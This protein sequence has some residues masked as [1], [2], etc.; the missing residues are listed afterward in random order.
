MKPDGNT[1]FFTSCGFEPCRPLIREDGEISSFVRRQVPYTVNYGTNSNAFYNPNPMPGQLV[2]WVSG[3]QGRKT[4]WG[5]DRVKE[6]FSSNRQLASP[7]NLLSM[8]FFLRGDVWRLPGMN[9]PFKF[10]V[11]TPAH[12]LPDPATPQVAQTQMPPQIDQM[13]SS[14]AI[15]G[16]Q[17]V[18]VEPSV[19]QLTTRNQRLWA[20]KHFRYKLR[21]CPAFPE[22][23]VE[24][25]SLLRRQ[26]RCPEKAESPLNSLLSLHHL[27]SNLILWLTA[28]GGVLRRAGDCGLLATGAPNFPPTNRVQATIR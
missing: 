26:F 5:Y 6:A 1:P 12:F 13:P 4:T 7:E 19:G 18:L 23:V 2:P 25:P 27:K 14:L 17:S 28:L 16:S 10:F 21:T 15:L 8:S 20:Y 3:F 11:N 24:M 22:E 9:G